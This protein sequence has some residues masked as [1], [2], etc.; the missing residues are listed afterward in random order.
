[1]HGL[2]V[3]LLFYHDS[4]ATQVLP[5]QEPAGRHVRNV[6]EGDRQTYFDAIAGLRGTEVGYGRSV[7][8]DGRCHAGLSDA[9]RSEL[10]VDL[11]RDV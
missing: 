11:G 10:A 9:L 6:I 1:M 7:K 4:L 3:R 5:L 8:G 2:S